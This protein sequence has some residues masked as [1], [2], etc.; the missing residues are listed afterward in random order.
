MLKDIL[1][2]TENFYPL[3]LIS[4]LKSKIS[5]S[6]FTLINF[7]FKTDFPKKKKNNAEILELC[8]HLCE[9]S[10]CRALKQIFLLV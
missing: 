1:K 4:M 10:V 9:I 7:N 8:H 6:S 2:F 5:L 3:N